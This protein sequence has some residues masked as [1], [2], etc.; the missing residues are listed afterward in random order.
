[1]KNIAYFLFILFLLQSCNQTKTQK[2]TNLQNTSTSFTINGSVND[3]T[4]VKVYLNKVIDKNLYPVDSANITN[5]HFIFKGKVLY[6]ERYAI[7]FYNSNLVFP[8]ILE[9]SLLNIKIN[10]FL[11]EDSSITGSALNNL[12]T[13][14]K[15]GAKAIFKQLD[16]LYPAFQKARLENNVA[17]LKNIGAN[18]KEIENAYA[19][20]TFDFI[21]KHSNSALAAILLNDQLQATKADSIQIKNSYSK[22]SD[23]IKLLPVSKEI[24]KKLGLN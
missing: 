5:S 12:E 1:M 10:K 24:A 6:P 3:S 9:N 13:T 2:E 23:S 8:F 22:L 21:N 4:V 16:N 15:L 14:Y 17:K 19:T 11:V 7:T 20:Y 18:V